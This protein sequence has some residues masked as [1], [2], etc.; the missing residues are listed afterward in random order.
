MRRYTAI[1]VDIAIGIH[2]DADVDLG[3]GILNSYMQYVLAL[4]NVVKLSSSHP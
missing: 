3:G 4:K 1:D 2:R